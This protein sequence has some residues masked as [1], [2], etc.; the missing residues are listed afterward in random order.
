MRFFV[1]FLTRS[2]GC[3]AALLLAPA[4]GLWPSATWRALWALITVI[5]IFGEGR[6]DSDDNIYGVNTCPKLIMKIFTEESL[7]HIGRKH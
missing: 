3:Y 6:L 7:S 1:L 2:S 4:E 5:E